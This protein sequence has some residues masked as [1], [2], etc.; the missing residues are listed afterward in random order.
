VN[1]E[2]LIAPPLHFADLTPWSLG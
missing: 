2:T 1:Y